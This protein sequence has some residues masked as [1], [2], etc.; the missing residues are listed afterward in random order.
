MET[1]ST[2]IRDWLENYMVEYECD[3]CHGARLKDE[4]LSVKIANKSIY[5]VTCMSI[6]E[7]LVFFKNLE[8][9]EEKKQIANLIFERNK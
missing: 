8:L 2:W 7:L 1:N 5:E 9:T 6:K 3:T 4:V